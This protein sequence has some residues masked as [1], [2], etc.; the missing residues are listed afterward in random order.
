[1][2]GRK[3]IRCPNVSII[4][5]AVVSRIPF[6]M[7]ESNVTP[8]LFRKAWSNFATGVT[9]I[10]TREANGSDGVHGMTANGVASVS[11]VPPLALAVIAHGRN[12]HPLVSRNLRFGLS[13]LATDQAPVARHFTVPA[14]ARA[15]MDPVAT[16]ELGKSAVIAGALTAMDCRVVQ[17]IESGDHT[18]F[19]A[20]VEEIKLNRGEPLIYFRS[21]FA[22]LH[23]G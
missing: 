12:T 16:V 7:T 10:T 4:G 14:E 23:V 5:I 19:I 8:D 22:E 2:R 1:M 9:V 20:E 21:E 13:V 3:P 6:A 15:S 17:S 18:I 11:L